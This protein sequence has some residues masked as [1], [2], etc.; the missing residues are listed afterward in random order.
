MCSSIGFCTHK[1]HSVTQSQMFSLIQHDFSLSHPDESPPRAGRWQREWKARGQ[2]SQHTSS[3][4]E[5]HTKHTSSF[6]W[7]KSSYRN[8]P[9]C[10]EAHCRNHFK[11]Q[12]FWW[13]W[14]SCW[15]FDMTVIVSDVVLPGSDPVLG[16][17]HI[18]SWPYAVPKL[19]SES[20]WK[21]F[22]IVYTGK[23]FD[24]TLPC[25]QTAF[26]YA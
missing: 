18:H 13:F 15:C 19:L 21:H 17:S 22:S 11:C 23:T 24:Q 9:Y 1:T 10:Y 8:Q 25:Q 2:S 12:Q 26:I 3:P 5:L 7:D 16:R 20:M 4:S 14:W 6:S